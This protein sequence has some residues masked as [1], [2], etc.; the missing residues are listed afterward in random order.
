[1]SIDLC[2]KSQD[3]SSLSERGGKFAPG[4]S[5]QLS[6]ERGW[7]HWSLGRVVE[8]G[9]TWNPVGLTTA[10]ATP[11]SIASPHGGRN[12]GESGRRFWSRG[13]Q[14]EGFF[15]AYRLRAASQEE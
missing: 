14:R 10:L 1:M 6:N 15:A 13:R 8:V 4:L 5:W 3:L 7:K 11:R 12:V 2:A 9:R